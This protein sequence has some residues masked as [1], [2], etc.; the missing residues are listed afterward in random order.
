M[1][2]N[3]HGPQNFTLSIFLINLSRFKKRLRING[4][5]YILW[6]KYETGIVIA[7]HWNKSASL[8]FDKKLA[9]IRNQFEIE[10]IQDR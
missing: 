2:Q 4:L 8:I 5:L 9:I 6:K 3:I 10:K 7:A 1:H